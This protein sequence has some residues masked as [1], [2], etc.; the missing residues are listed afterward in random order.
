MVRR[1]APQ[2]PQKRA[3]ACSRWPQEPQISSVSM[4]R[5]FRFTPAVLRPSGRDL[6]YDAPVCEARR[7]LVI[8]D[9][10]AEAVGFKNSIG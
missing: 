2:A 3:P 8:E 6:V 1:S 4:A 10:V 5:S 7:S 9:V